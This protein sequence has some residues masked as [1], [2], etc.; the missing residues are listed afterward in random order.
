MI[1]IPKTLKIER[2][3]R[4]KSSKRSNAKP[5][6]KTVALNHPTFSS[7]SP[8]ATRLS[9]RDEI[10]APDLTPLTGSRIM[11]ASGLQALPDRTLP[12]LLEAA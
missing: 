2:A 4:M 1:S 11:G 8:N 10:I 3:A 9:L 7:S 6:I 12:A 5:E